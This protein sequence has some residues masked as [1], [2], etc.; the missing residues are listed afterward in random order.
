[1][2]KRKGTFLEE[3]VSN[4]FRKAGF[5]TE[6]GNNEHDF[7]IDV[8]A[9][10]KEFKVVIEC[11]QYDNSYINI[12]S[13]LH[14]WRSKGEIAEAHRTIVVVAGMEIPEKFYTL[15]RKL[16]VYLMGDEEIHYFLSLDKDELKE[17]LNEKINFD[18]EKQIQKEK[19][20]KKRSIE[21]WALKIGIALSVLTGIYYVLFKVL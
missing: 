10:R 17:R 1:M 14:E 21:R 8:L 6:V 9:K 13:L 3:S 2:A 19:L 16:G 5:E 12:S 7:E 18:I 11:K 15:A 4:L 20:A